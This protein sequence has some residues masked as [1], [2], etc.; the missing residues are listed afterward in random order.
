MLVTFHTVDTEAQSAHRNV[1]VVTQRLG[2]T[3]EF[4][5]DPSDSWP[6]RCHLQCARILWLWVLWQDAQL[7]AGNL[8]RFLPVTIQELTCILET[9]FYLL[10]CP[11]IKIVDPLR[12]CLKS[13]GFSLKQI[14]NPSC[15]IFFWCPVRAPCCLLP[16]KLT[17]YILD[18]F[19]PS[20]VQCV[21]NTDISLKI[22]N[23][24]M[25]TLKF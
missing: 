11:L 12:I 23:R 15:F 21:L 7:T 9:H 3:V 20:L 4:R 16:K 18:S 6:A 2:G 1:S 10:I 5:P 17:V 19:F 14:G 22:R 8:S 24:F 13:A 25:N